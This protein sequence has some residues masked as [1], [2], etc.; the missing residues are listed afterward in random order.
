MKTLLI[1]VFVNFLF[2]CTFAQTPIDKKNELLKEIGATNGFIWE[3]I[4]YQE[5]IYIAIVFWE[6]YSRMISSLMNG[7][8]NSK[9]FQVVFD[10]SG[11]WKVVDK[12]NVQVVIEK[13]NTT[14]NYNF[15]NSYETMVNDNGYLFKRRKNEFKNNTNNSKDSTSV[16]DKVDSG[17]KEEIYSKEVKIGNQIWMTKNL[18]IDTFRNGDLIPQAKTI[19]EWKR[20][21]E[22][23]QPAWCYYNNDLG[24]GAKYGK[25][26]NWYAVIDSRG[27]APTG[28]HIPSDLEWTTLTDYLGDDLELGNKLKNTNGWADNRNGTNS[29]GFSALPGGYRSYNGGFYSMGS[30]GYWWSSTENSSLSAWDRFLYSISGRFFRN[31][32]GKDDGHSVRCLRD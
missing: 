26:Y 20:A 9:D 32:G 11:N 7:K 30:D 15:S 5:D 4:N 2:V 28:Y 16:N 19:E 22:N 17:M 24:N 13:L 31:E 6:S 1:F 25:L 12:N 29:S 21:G 8:T 3:Y 23:K 14:I 18:D 27:L 10:L